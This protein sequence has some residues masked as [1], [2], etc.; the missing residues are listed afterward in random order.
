MDIGHAEV[1][2][3]LNHRL[4]TSNPSPPQQGEAGT[5]PALTLDFAY[6]CLKH[7]EYL[8]PKVRLQFSLKIFIYINNALCTDFVI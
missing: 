7:A 4:V 6:V 8:L 3:G 2:S 5:M 1:G